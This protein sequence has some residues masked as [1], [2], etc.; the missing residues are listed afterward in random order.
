M[1]LRLVAAW[2]PAIAAIFFAVNAAQAD[3]RVALVIGNA[4]YQ[5]VGKLTNTLIDSRSVRDTL[6]KLGFNVI[7]GENLNKRLIERRIGDFAAAVRDADVAIVYFA[8]H[9]ATFGDIPYVVPTDAEYQLIERVPYELVQVEQLLGELRRA[10]GVRIAI[11]DACRDNAREIELKRSDAQQRGKSTRGGALSRGLAPVKNADGLIIAYSAQLLTTAGD[12]TPGHNSPF[13]G[14][15]V[16]FMDQPDLDVKAMFFKVAQ[17][18]IETTK[19]QQ[20]PEISISM[21]DDYVLRRGTG[22]PA[23]VAAPAQAAPAAV[24]EAVWNTIKDS[25]VA[26]VFEEFERKFPKSAR[27]SEARARQQE[28]KNTAV[29]VRSGPPVVDTGKLMHDPNLIYRIETRGYN[30][31]TYV[32]AVFTR[33]NDGN[34]IETNKGDKTVQFHFTEQKQTKSEIVMYDELRDLYL[35]FDL[36]AQRLLFRQGKQ[37]WNP[38][39]KIVNTSR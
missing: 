26:A 4:E 37:N 9:G 34:W 8:G 3:K 20:R 17:D 14:A 15:L 32:E 10:K 33:D 16:K 38:F 35:R 18:V 6:T 21:F 12:G 36:A 25:S 31:P 5:H 1:R 30:G 2:I 24:D 13:T 19:G 7:Y 39:Y 11:L 27:V 23:G 22:A 29:A 28:L